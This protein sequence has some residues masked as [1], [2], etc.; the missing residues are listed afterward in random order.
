MSEH[1]LWLDA[2]HEV[3]GVAQTPAYDPANPRTPL[4]DTQR[5]AYRT[6]VDL[7]DQCRK[8]WLAIPEP[9][10]PLHFLSYV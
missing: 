9:D 2:Y 8:A 6:L 10:R 1:A 5:D 7:I 4:T 3:L